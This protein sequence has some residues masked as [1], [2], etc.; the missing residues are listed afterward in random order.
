MLQSRNQMTKIFRCRLSHERSDHLHDISFK[1]GVISWSQ[2]HSESD[3]ANQLRNEAS[4]MSPTCLDADGRLLAPSLCHPHVHLDKAF[5]L[6][7]PKYRD[8]QVE[9]GTFAE[10]M[11]LT[12]NAK[13]MFEMDD[14]LQR[15]RR[16]IEESVQAGVTHMRA[17]FE[18]DEIVGLKCLEAG[19]ELKREAQENGSCH[20]QLCAFAQ[21]PLR[22]LEKD[23][24]KIRA[25][26]EEAMQ[27]AYLVDVIGSTPYVES[28][29]EGQR[30]N[31]DWM[32]EHA[33]KHGKHLDFHMDYSVDPN[34][35]V[36]TRYLLKTLKENN[37]KKNS[38]SSITLGHCTRLIYLSADELHSLVSEIGDLPVSFVGLP[39]SDMYMMKT[40]KSDGKQTQPEQRTT[41]H[42]PRLINQFGLNA[43]IGMNNIGNAFTPAGCCD[44]LYLANLGVG[45]YQTG[46]AEDAH[47]LYSCVSS[48]ARAAIGI[49]SAH[50]ATQDALTVTS[51]QNAD[52]V[53]FPAPH[54][55]FETEQGIEDQ[56]YYYRA[57]GRTVIKDGRIVHT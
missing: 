23:G 38:E 2:P 22:P 35:P 30:A 21:L 16:L 25:L 19:A 57:T 50:S 39:T 10:A 34:T 31:I 51:G 15:G 8:F 27:P 41:L 49:G 9:K 1:N 26:M 42:I 20:I 53:L 56:V 47:L 11:E 46:T 36:M 24:E 52:L 55:G 14:L 13:K 43:A 54:P 44:P 29:E 40:S 33:L 5:I 18:V 28:S 4:D 48:R 6:G 17:F 3:L 37:W 12:G 32:V 7:H 45:I